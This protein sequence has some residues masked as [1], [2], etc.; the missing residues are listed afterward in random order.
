MTSIE[1]E[2]ADRLCKALSETNSPSRALSML[3]E[4][5]SI[6]YDGFLFYY[7][8]NNSSEL[9]DKFLEEICG[10]SYNHLNC[11]GKLGRKHA[12]I[13][14]NVYFNDYYEEDPNKNK[15]KAFCN[16][17]KNPEDIDSDYIEIYEM[18]AKVRKEDKFFFREKLKF[19]VFIMAS[20]KPN[21]TLDQL[22]HTLN[23]SDED[24]NDLRRKYNL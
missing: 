10:I 22:Q 5:D 4:D 20:E 14:Y 18:E 11:S 23:L 2:F 24:M 1:L 9:I 3:F 8:D 16:T 7:L 19:P 21:F 13:L 17:T 12:C 15:I 6:E